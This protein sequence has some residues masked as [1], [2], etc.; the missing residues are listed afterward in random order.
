MIFGIEEDDDATVSRLLI[1]FHRCI[2]CALAVQVSSLWSEREVRIEM[3]E[4]NSIKIVSYRFKG[5]RRFG[6]RTARRE[7]NGN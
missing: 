6:F 3:R 2:R 1:R 7:S 5:V 4:G